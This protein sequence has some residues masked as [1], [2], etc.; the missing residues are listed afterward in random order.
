MTESDQ[1]IKR[2]K[3]LTLILVLLT[4]GAITSLF[5]NIILDNNTATNEL[6]LEYINSR[7]LFDKAMVYI[8]N[9]FLLIICFFIIK[10]SA[11]SI[12][13]YK[14]YVI[15]TYVSFLIHTISSNWYIY[16]GSR[17]VLTS[18]IG[19]IITI[20]IIVYLQTLKKRNYFIEVK[21]DF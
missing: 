6:L 15:L 9:P 7:S 4:Y 18:I 21:R 13:L 2:P 20:A 1:L 12:P 14:T 10:R 19:L 8:L 11:L 3:V 5:S 17:G 16:F